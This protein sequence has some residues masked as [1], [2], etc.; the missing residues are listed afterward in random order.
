MANLSSET[1]AKLLGFVT[2]E[3]ISV[4]GEET[5]ASEIVREFP[6]AATDLFLAGVRAGAE[7]MF[8]VINY[9]F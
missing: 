6:E 9:E 7:A 3:L 4:A 1:K 5:P 2:D 8:K